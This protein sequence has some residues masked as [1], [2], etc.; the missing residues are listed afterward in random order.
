MLE[1]LDSHMQRNKSQPP[2]HVILKRK[3]LKWARDLTLRVKTIETSRSRQRVHLSDSGLVK[4]IMKK[5]Q[6]TKEI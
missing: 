6:A 5:I 4:I 3:T 2:Y 1:R